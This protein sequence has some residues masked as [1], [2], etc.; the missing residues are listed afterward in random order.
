MI[1]KGQWGEFGQD[2]GVTPLL[3]TRSAMGFF[4]TTERQNLGSSSH[5][6]QKKTKF[7]YMVYFFKGCD[8]HMFFVEEIIEDVSSIAKR[9]PKV[10]N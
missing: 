9:W 5:L 1:D 4:M 3:F 8:V 6:S 7:Y 2:D 10:N